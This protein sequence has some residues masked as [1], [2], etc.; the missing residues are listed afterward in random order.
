MYLTG[1]KEKAENGRFLTGNMLKGIAAAAMV[2][3]HLAAVVLKGYVNAALPHISSQQ[4][5]RWNMVYEWMRHIGRTAFPLFAFLL[6][7][8]FFHTGDR[9]KYGTRLF[10]FALLS[11]LPYDLAVYGSIC[12]WEK[13]NVL[14]SLFLGLVLLQCMERTGRDD[15]GQGRREGKGSL[16]AW[17]RLLLQLLALLAACGLAYICRLDYSYKG[18]LLIAVFYFL[19]QYQAAAAVGGFCVFSWSPWSFPAFLLLPFYNGR[20][21][22][23]GYRWFYLFYPLHLLLLYGILQISLNSFII[24]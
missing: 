11:E 15:G 3:D 9:K 8:G 16:P 7:E 6:V 4:L 14:F 17:G 19:H 12:S 2:I 1:K 18:M 21:G 22:Q 5:I 23:R 13:Q 10:L 20:R 24:K